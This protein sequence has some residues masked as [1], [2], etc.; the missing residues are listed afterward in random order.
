[1]RPEQEIACSNAAAHRFVMKS[2]ARFS[3]VA[4]QMSLNTPHT[5]VVPKHASCRRLPQ[6]NRQS[7]PPVYYAKVSVMSQFVS[8]NWET[9]VS[10]LLAVLAFAGVML[11]PGYLAARFGRL[12]VFQIANG[13]EQVLWS[14]VLSA[15]IALMLAVLTRPI[16][17]NQLTGVCFGLLDLLAFADW[18]RNRRQTCLKV[19]TAI[20]VVAICSTSALLLAGAPVRIGLNL[21]EPVASADWSVRVPLIAA[22]IRD[23]GTMTNPF[24]AVGGQLTPLHYYYYWYALCGVV[25]RSLSLAPRAMMA[26]GTVWACLLMLATLF[27]LLKTLFR[28]TESSTPTRWL[29]LSLGACMA[30]PVLGFDVLQVGY[31]F[32]RHHALWPEPEWWRAPSAETPSFQT[33]LLYAPHHTFGVCACLT[34]FL[35]L[36]LPKCYP[37]RGSAKPPGIAV[38]G[39][40]AGVCFAA[41]AGTSTYVALCFCVVSVLLVGERAFAK[42]W[43]TIATLGIA[44][45]VAVALS[46]SFL[47]MMMSP[48]DGTP[49]THLIAISLRSWS[50]VGAWIGAHQFAPHPSTLARLIRILFYLAF[51]VS[52]LGFLLL[53]FLYRARKDA[54]LGYSLS[55]R[56]RMQWILALGFALPNFL[57]SSAALI[58]SNDLGFHT[59]FLLRII[60]VLWAAPLFAQLWW[61]KPW[62]QRFFASSYGRLATVCVLLGLLSQ[63]W[64]IVIQRFGLLIAGSTFVIQGPF[65]A[66][67]NLGQRYLAAYQANQAVD[68]LLPRDARLLT[69]PWSAQRSMGMLYLNRQTIAPEPGCMVAFGGSAARCARALPSLAVLFGEELSEDHS[70][71][72]TDSAAPE[73]IFKRVC[74]E[75]HASAV[76]VSADDRGWHDLQSWIWI[77]HPIYSSPAER[78][79][80]CPSR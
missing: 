7:V 50:A 35:L 11:A 40:L 56:A 16:L 25:G 5:F 37:L 59:A 9:G 77:L 15:P 71:L 41:V 39:V 27:L 58:G 57:L 38:P 33:M 43:R 73:R 28:P 6:H 76:L 62:R 36:I 32:F 23:G 67:P 64:Q 4:A 60:G 30:M 34:G 17:G 53:V 45:A 8:D 13:A 19:P 55:S 78:L 69:N 42:D 51:E 65:P 22:A 75:Q 12:W 46:I 10:S 49:H 68:E 47:R 18:W 24:Y 44:A 61:N 54:R 26:A 14:V 2:F 66:P 74:V 21:W 80:L 3:G 31:L 52:E 70:S 63:G 72:A 48:V 1:M 29:H 20:V 79:F